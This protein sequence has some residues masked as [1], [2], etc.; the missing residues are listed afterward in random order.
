MSRTVAP[1]LPMMA[2]TDAGGMRKFTTPTGDDEA[3]APFAV[4]TR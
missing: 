2:D 1:P 4:A 3:L